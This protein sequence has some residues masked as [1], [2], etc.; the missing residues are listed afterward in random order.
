[1]CCTNCD[2][3]VFAFITQV[4]PV[5]KKFFEKSWMQAQRW[6]VERNVS[7]RRNIFCW[8][9]LFSD[10]RKRNKYFIEMCFNWRSL[11]CTIKIQ[12]LDLIYSIYLVWNCSH[13]KPVLIVY[14]YADCWSCSNCS[15]DNLCCF[16]SEEHLHRIV[17]GREFN[18]FAMFGTCLIV[19][20]Y[21]YLTN[22]L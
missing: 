6:T 17:S 8:H 3:I 5:D 9:I 21:K 15:N 11:G 10:R 14:K 4:K 18:Q 20:V 2:Q 16:G 13:V 1:M 22:Y 7:E 19:C 12:Y